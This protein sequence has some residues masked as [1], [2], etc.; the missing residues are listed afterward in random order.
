MLQPDQYE[1]KWHYDSDGNRV[2]TMIR[3][4]NPVMDSIRRREFH[5]PQE[6]T[7][8][9]TTGGGHGLLRGR[10]DGLDGVSGRRNTIVSGR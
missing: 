10:G 1:K 7:T 3:K 9:C 6:E 2:C 5:L 4:R 8:K